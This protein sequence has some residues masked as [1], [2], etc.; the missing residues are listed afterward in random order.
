MKLVYFLMI[1][2]S[3]T[4][5]GQQIELEG[6]NDHT[7]ATFDRCQRLSPKRQQQCKK[8]PMSPF[9][10]YCEKHSPARICQGKTKAGKPCKKKTKSNFCYLHLMV[11]PVLR[12]RKREIDLRAFELF[13]AKADATTALE[14]LI[15]AYNGDARAIFLAGQLIERNKNPYSSIVKSI[16]TGGKEKF[17]A[18]QFLGYS[19]AYKEDDRNTVRL[20]DFATTPFTYARKSYAQLKSKSLPEQDKLIVCD[21]FLLGPI[22]YFISEGDTVLVYDTENGAYLQNASII[23]LPPQPR[24]VQ[25]VLAGENVALVETTLTD[26]E[27]KSVTDTYDAGE[28]YVEAWLETELPPTVERTYITYH[29]I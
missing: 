15:D 10:P 6:S 18:P 27:L 16:I 9:R 20:W 26:E 8:P 23:D 21:I 14:I 13:A 5:Q 25:L 24:I 1:V 11:L 19:I 12:L 2:L 4:V 29:N 3:S 28:D 22:M 17:H 7:A